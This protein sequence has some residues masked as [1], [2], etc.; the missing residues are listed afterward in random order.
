VVRRAER[1]LEEAGGCRVP[2]AELCRAAGA[3]RRSLE[4]AFQAV[5]GVSPLRYMQARRLAHARRLLRES[6]PARGEVKHAAYEADFNFTEMGRFSVDCR[7]FFGE[8]PSATL[9]G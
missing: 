8:P 7:R 6:P 1:Y 9:A 2:V 5:Y 4:Y 3:S